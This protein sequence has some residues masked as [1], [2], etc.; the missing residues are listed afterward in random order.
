MVLHCSI[1]QRLHCSI[2]PPVGDQQSPVGNLAADCAMST[3]CKGS[4]RY[5]LYYIYAIYYCVLLYSNTVYSY[6][7]PVYTCIYIYYNIYCMDPCTFW[8]MIL[9]ATVSPFSG[10]AVSGSIGYAWTY[11]CSLHICSWLIPPFLP[12]ILTMDFPLI[13]PVGKLFCS[14]QLCMYI[15]I[16]IHQYTIILQRF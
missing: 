12:V 2:L 15:Y 10:S 9:V 16:Y 14:I 11:L 13:V 3:P 1:P 8:G 4:R 7:I 6:L 5:A